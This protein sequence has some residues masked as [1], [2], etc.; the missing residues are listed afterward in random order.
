MSKLTK[1]MENNKIIKTRR[2]LGNGAKNLIDTRRCDVLKYLQVHGSIAVELM[3]C[4]WS[5]PQG[6]YGYVI[7]LFN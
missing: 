2:L 5:I 1:A 4:G 6:G 7:L 3:V